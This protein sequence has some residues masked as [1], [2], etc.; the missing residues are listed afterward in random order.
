MILAAGLGTRMAPLTRSVPKP[1]LPV[2][3]EPMILRMIRQL[4]AYG[5]ERVVI[6]V[7]AFPSVMEQAVAEAPIPVEL[8]LEPE[9]LGSLG[10]IRAARRHLEGTAPFLVLNADMV[11]ETDLAQLEHIHRESGAL[12]TLLLR[13]DARKHAFGTIGYR[14]DGAVHR[15]TDQI[16]LGSEKGS[17]LFTGIQLLSPE[18]LDHIPDRPVSQ[19]MRDLYV[20]LLRAGARVMAA[21][22]EPQ[23]PWWPMGTPREL[24]DTNLLALDAEVA[25]HG[26]ADAVLTDT[27]ARIDGIV[28]GPAWIGAGAHVPSGARLGPGVVLG[29]RAEVPDGLEAREMLFLC[30][31]RPRA[32]QPLRRAI[33]FDQEV[34]RDA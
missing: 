31:A 13:E 7:H 32:R 30:G 4:A 9:L 17:G 10:G 25:R 3:G 29:A 19:L 5:I 14:E 15:I 12:A 16:S 11:F 6:N 23:D 1:A 33:A 28:V 18:V 2:L 8:S 21:H 34:W 27:N 26:S 22:M 20:P 24:L